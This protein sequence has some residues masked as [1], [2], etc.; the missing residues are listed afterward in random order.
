MH[1]YLKDSMETRNYSDRVFGLY[2][3]IFI[4]FYSN[5]HKTSSIRQQQVLKMD[6]TMNLTIFQS[7]FSYLRS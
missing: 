7:I 3:Y 2:I 6:L 5:F 1:S 4:K